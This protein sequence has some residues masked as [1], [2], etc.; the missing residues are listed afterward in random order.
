MTIKEIEERS[1]MTRANIRFYESEGLLKPERKEN[2]YRAYSPADLE[3]LLR[4]RLLRALG[5]SLDELRALQ[6]GEAELP[7]ALRRQLDALLAE[8]KALERARSVC[9]EMLDDGAQ[10]ATLDA[11]RYLDALS[12]EAE[13]PAAVPQEDAIPKVRAPW[14]R[15][16]ARTLDF[17][18][19]DLGCTLFLLALNVD[20]ALTP[21][22]VSLFLTC[23]IQLFL[24]PLFL[25][26]LGTT[27]GKWLLGL[28]VASPDGDKLSYSDAMER[29]WTVW[30]YGF[31]MNIPILHAYRLYKCCNDCTN[32]ETLP[33][34]ENSTLSLRD[35]KPWRWAAYAGAYAVMFA[36]LVLSL[37]VHE[38]PKHRG[39]ITVAEFC[40][41]YNRYVNYYEPDI[42]DRLD[43]E[44]H[45]VR[46]TPDGAVVFV[47]GDVPRPELA[48]TEENG[49]M[50][51]VSFA[52]TLED[53]VFPPNYSKEAMYFILAFAG[54]QKG[55]GLRHQ[56]AR[57]AADALSESAYDDFSRSVYGV[58]IE[59]DVDYEGYRVISDS[60]LWSEDGMHTNYTVSFTMSK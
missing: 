5:V 35:E 33:W 9:R 32:G 14:R 17:T 36:L 37:Y 53:Q 19:C 51:G 43:S 2:G 40:E 39:D 60:T 7:D 44:G 15:F 16:L 29:L 6:A 45:W 46:Q 8:Q 3:T 47:L 56:A 10:Y 22:I 18:L 4:I 20:P 50:T 59:R 11:P 12:R 25:S 54:A 24:E 34:E 27:P 31:G 28:S 49:C 52:Q 58:R 13:T 38:M 1:G 57:E 26:T 42:P 55:A 21:G 30:W 41:N 48:F 23:L